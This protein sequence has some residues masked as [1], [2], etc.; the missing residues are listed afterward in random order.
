MGRFYCLGAPSIKRQVAVLLDSFFVSLLHWNLLQAHSAS[1]SLKTYANAFVFACEM[2]H[3]TVMNKYI[4]WFA[5][6]FVRV[7]VLNKLLHF[8]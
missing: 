3:C 2:K 8:S 4:T 5:T 6:S 7:I 1:V